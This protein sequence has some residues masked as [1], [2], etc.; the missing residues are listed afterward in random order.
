MSTL[1]KLRR[2]VLRQD[3]SVREDHLDIAGSPT[4]PSVLKQAVQDDV[5]ALVAGTEIDIDN[6]AIVLA[7]GP[8]RKRLFVVARQEQRRNA[9]VFEASGADLVVLSGFVIAAEVLR[10]LRAPLLSAFLRRARDES[11]E[12]AASLLERLRTTIGDDVL[13]SWTVKIDVSSAPTFA[14]S[15]RQGLS[16]SVRQLLTGA[17]SHEQRVRAVPLLLM[18]ELPKD[19]HKLLLPDDDTPLSVGDLVL[20]CGS[21]SARARMQSRLVA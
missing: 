16:V 10:Q 11:E 2:L 17:G 21:A 4:D 8:Q 1:S 20:M 18:R 12:W 6:L 13:E 19:R 7:A 9:N 14:Q 5:G 3:V 15:I